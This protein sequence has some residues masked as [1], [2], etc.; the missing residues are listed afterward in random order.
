[1][2]E[3]DL[4]AAIVALVQRELSGDATSIGSCQIE[5]AAGLVIE[6]MKNRGLDPVACFQLGQMDLFN[7]SA[8]AAAFQII[9]FAGCDEPDCI[10]CEVCKLLLTNTDDLEAAFKSLS[11]DHE[12]GARWLGRTLVKIQSRPG[13]NRQR[14]EHASVALGIFMARSVIFDRI[15]PEYKQLKADNE[16]LRATIDMLADKSLKSQD[17]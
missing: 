5:R 14:A 12:Q 11:R 1:M 15:M 3:D 4:K 9:D 17:V 2:T 10:P 16:K 6:D 7:E 8:K 13:A